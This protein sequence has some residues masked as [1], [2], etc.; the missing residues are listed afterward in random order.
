MKKTLHV[1]KAAGVFLLFL[2]LFSCKRGEFSDTL[3]LE[4]NGKSITA[5]VKSDTTY[6]I[7]S[8]AMDTTNIA[9]LTNVYG[10]ITLF[11]PTNSAFKKYFQRKGISGL[12]DMNLNAIKALL[13]YHLYGRTY[14]SS[15]FQTGSLPT[16]TVQ[17]DYISM[18]IK[19]GVKNAVLNGTTKVVKLDIQ[20]TNGVVHSIDDVLEPPLNTV[21]SLIKSLPQY[22]IMAEAFEK[23]GLGVTLLDPVAY[24]PAN[25]QY[26]KP[27][28]KM[29]TVFLET[30]D[31]LNAA[32]IYSFADLATKFSKQTY[33]PTNVYTSSTDSLNIFM[34]YHVIERGYFISDIKSE[35]I[36]TY[37]PADFL[38]FDIS[39]AYT[40]NRT[41]G[42]P[43]EMD[44]DKSNLIAN[45]GIVNSVKSVLKVYNPT[46]VLSINKFIPSAAPAITLPTLPN[47]TPGVLTA[48]LMGQWRAIPANQ[49]GVPWLKW[50]YGSTAIFW[51]APAFF[52]GQPSLKYNEPVGETSFWVEITTDQIIKGQYDLYLIY[53]W[54]ANATNK[55]THTC[56]LEFDGQPYGDL[57][58]LLSMS[59]AYN[60][61]PDAMK[62]STA[63][64]GIIRGDQKIERKLGSLTFSSLGK[65]RLKITTVDRDT[66]TYFYSIELRPR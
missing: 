2:T 7:L 55:T 3:N 19:D 49:A 30:N 44:F 57:V 53:A 47:G 5:L 40:I 43:V 12:S 4:A 46:P 33:S 45:N 29:R 23:T 1:F 34:K 39:P 50:S 37:S 66:K 62:K 31:V 25:I 15:V 59:D 21:N 20:V 65:H 14:T 16:I 52:G 8:R 42:K 24:D 10:S 60:S 35:V 17:G 54:Q 32:G 11:A 61:F 26:G 56:L 58:N 63:E 9:A 28:K 22:S 41:S 18:N 6:S 13:E 38:L 48:G 36:E 51:D 27:A 64:P